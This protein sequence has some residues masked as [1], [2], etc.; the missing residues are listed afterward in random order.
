MINIY[1]HYSPNGWASNNK[2]VIASTSPNS[3][4]DQTDIKQVEYSKKQYFYYRVEAPTLLTPEADVSARDSAEL[5]QKFDWEL[6][7]TTKNNI[8]FVA[9]EDGI[10]T[11]SNT[12]DLND[13]DF[14]S[15]SYVSGLHLNATPIS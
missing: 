9:I 12:I 11:T 2:Y 8:T 5:T 4:A 3:N 14:Y 15:S 6:N 10:D 13:D 1:A 7:G